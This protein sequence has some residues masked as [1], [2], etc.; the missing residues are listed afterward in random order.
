MIT[1]AV[2]L[3]QLFFVGLMY[4]GNRLGPRIGVALM[5]VSLLWTATH[6]FFPPLMLLQAS[7]IVL[8]WWMFRKKH[9]GAGPPSPP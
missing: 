1:V 6:L 4:L 2:I 8:S 3:Y 5:L 9:H 7:I